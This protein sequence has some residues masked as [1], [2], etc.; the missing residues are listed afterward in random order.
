MPR[1]KVCIDPQIDLLVRRYR[2]FRENATARKALDGCRKKVQSWR[3]NEEPAFPDNPTAFH[4]PNWLGKQKRGAYP[5]GFDKAGA[6]V[7]IDWTLPVGIRKDVDHLE[8]VF[9]NMFGKAE[10]V[11][12]IYHEKNGE[13]HR[14]LN[15]SYRGGFDRRFVY[16]DGRPETIITR[17]WEHDDLDAAIPRIESERTE[18]EPI[19]YTKEGKVKGEVRS[20]S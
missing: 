8:A 11:R 3:Y 5:H 19:R 20:K 16:K 1:K 6:L 7:L 13:P 10:V 18:K 4:H 14:V 9:V 15:L 17:Y 12:H 2:T